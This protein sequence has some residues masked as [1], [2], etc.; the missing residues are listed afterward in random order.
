MSKDK[1]S[2]SMKDIPSVQ[3][4]KE[5]VL[6]V[7]GTGRSRG[8]AGLEKEV[9]KSLDLSKEQRKYRIKGSSTTL[10]SNRFKDAISELKRDGVITSPSTGKIKI[11]KS[12][13]ETSAASKSVSDTKS[14][15]IKEVENLE[16][17]SKNER[18]DEVKL[19]EAGQVFVNKLQETAA[20]KADEFSQALTAKL[21][22]KIDDFSSRESEACNEEEVSEKL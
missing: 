5:A 4:I 6:L 22:D 16:D 12:S 3:E 10:I 7:G 9:Y 20:L 13:E 14:T 1:S 21:Q 15:K 2:V 11:S 18:S 17:K 8:I 19:S